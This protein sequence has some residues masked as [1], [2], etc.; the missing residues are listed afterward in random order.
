MTTIKVLGPGCRNCITLEARTRQALD[1]LGMQ[2]EVEKVTDVAQIMSYG[3]M[4]TP[5]LVVDEQV[6]IA[7]KVPSVRKLT[8]L[9]AQS[10]T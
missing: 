9:L 1:D 3:I 5:G 10:S 6:V 2:A 4:S 7:G 8:E